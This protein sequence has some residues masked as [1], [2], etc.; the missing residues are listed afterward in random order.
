MTWWRRHF[1]AAE[2]TLVVAVSAAFAAWLYF[3]A[4]ATFF[5][6]ERSSDNLAVAAALVSLFGTLLGFIIAAITFL[7]GI[8]DKEAFKILRASFSYRDHWRIFKSCLNACA[9]AT[10]LSVVAL[11]CFWIK[12]LPLVVLVVAFAAVILSVARIGRVV[13][14]IGHM[15]D[16]EVR[17]GNETRTDPK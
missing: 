3:G 1:M 17:L 9:L 7:F 16:A 15:I 14:V 13:W 11:V 8:V 4:G 5:S 6:L 12:V 10:L 2:G